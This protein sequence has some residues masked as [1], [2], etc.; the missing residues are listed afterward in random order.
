MLFETNNSNY[1][2]IYQKQ[3]NFNVTR[4]TLKD[5][6][7]KINNIR[8]N[9]RNLTKTQTKYHKFIINNILKNIFA[10]IPYNSNLH[11]FY[12]KMLKEFLAN[13]NKI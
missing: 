12:K 10:L 5:L 1:M 8:I 3:Q 6:K 9:I 11:T 13:I 4:H 7:N 2:K